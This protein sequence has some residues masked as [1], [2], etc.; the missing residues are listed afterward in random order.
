M[1]AKSSAGSGAE[2]GRSGSGELRPRDMAGEIVFLVLG[3]C[4]YF[5]TDA[6]G[7]G[8]GEEKEKEGGGVAGFSG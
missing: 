7:A 8:E 3:Y 4:S 2:R 6:G 1:G 5:G